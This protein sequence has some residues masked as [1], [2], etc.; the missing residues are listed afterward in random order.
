MFV[1]ALEIGIDGVLRGSLATYKKG[2]VRI[3]RKKVYKGVDRKMFVPG[4]V[5]GGLVTMPVVLLNE[6]TFVPYVFAEGSSVVEEVRMSAEEF[7]KMLDTT[8]LACAELLRTEGDKL[9]TLNTILIAVVLVIL[10]FTFF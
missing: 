8:S 4:R 7:G 5:F 2:V 1:W 3:G 9:M 6:K 10:V